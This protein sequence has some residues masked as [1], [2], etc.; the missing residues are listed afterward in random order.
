[1]NI[2]LALNMRV[3]IDPQFSADDWQLFT[4]SMDCS[5]VAEKLNYELKIIVNGNNARVIVEKHMHQWMAKF[6]EYGANDSEPIW[7]LEQV[8]GEIYG[9]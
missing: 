5:K 1:M 4:A 3:H 7:F 2:M 6:A 8:L 9:D